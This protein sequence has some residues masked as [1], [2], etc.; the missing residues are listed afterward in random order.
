MGGPPACRGRSEGFYHQWQ[1]AQAPPSR[2]IYDALKKVPPAISGRARADET[3][4]R[5][6]DQSNWTSPRKTD[7]E[8]RGKRP[9]RTR[10]G[11][12]APGPSAAGPGCRMLPGTRTRSRSPRPGS[13]SSR[14]GPVPT[15]G[16]RRSSPSGAYPSSPHAG[17][18]CT[19]SRAGRAAGGRGHWRT[20]GPDPSGR[21]GPR[22]GSGGWPSC[23][24]SC[25]WSQP[26]GRGHGGTGQPAVPQGGSRDAAV[27][28]LAR[29]GGDDRVPSG[30]LPNA[31]SVRASRSQFQPDLR[32]PPVDRPRR[33]LSSQRHE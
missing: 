7:T 9:V 26:C 3:T 4:R 16:P 31:A 22:R 21:P 27:E 30:R 15:S 18:C 2:Q 17:S 28:G 29:D 23:G 25:G 32:E 14:S 6:C 12:C 33:R 8:V 19:R 5:F 1:N 10:P 24:T 20:G 11:T 13:G